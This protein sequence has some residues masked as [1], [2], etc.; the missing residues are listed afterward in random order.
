M[1]ADEQRPSP[2]V[3]EGPAAEIEFE[4][5]VDL[6]LCRVCGCTDEHACEGGCSWVPDPA[7]EG[8]LCSRC[9]PAVAMGLLVQELLSWAV[10]TDPNL[11]C[12]RIRD[13]AGWADL[14][15]P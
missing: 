7:C 6:V 1:A 3:E 14:E 9:L 2:G 12:Q 8:D 15:V 10:R 13:L 5:D 4:P 11:D